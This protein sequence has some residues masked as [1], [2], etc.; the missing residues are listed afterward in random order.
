MQLNIQRITKRTTLSF[1][2]LL[3]IL[4]AMPISMAEAADENQRFEASDQWIKDA[5]TGIVWSRNANPAGQPMSWIDALEYVK[6]LNMRRFGGR[7]DWRLPNIDDLRR[8][9]A[10]VKQAGKIEAFSAALTVASVLKPYGFENL[11][12]GDYWSD[13][14]S[15]YNDTEA[16]YLDL[17]T[18]RKSTGKK[19]LLMFVWPISRKPSEISADPLWCCLP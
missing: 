7:D 6:Q 15:F 5:V 16:L 11:E 18:G 10:A 2:L 13:T 8:L 9:T 17:I 3:C 1:A 12:A 14:T 19:S 4:P